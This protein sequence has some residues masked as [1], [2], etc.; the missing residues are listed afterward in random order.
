MLI[1]V[2]YCLC[3][4]EL[5]LLVGRHPP[6]NMRQL[7]LVR[8]FGCL[9]IVLTHVNISLESPTKVLFAAWWRLSQ[10]VRVD[11]GHRVYLFSIDIEA[12]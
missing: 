4:L 7:P 1:L 9:D 10:R 3:V 8:C 11:V 5:S 6:Y 2:K 12:S